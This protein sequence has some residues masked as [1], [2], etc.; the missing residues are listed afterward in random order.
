MASCFGPALARIRL[1]PADEYFGRSKMSILEMNN[2][3]NDC[4]FRAQRHVSP[5]AI[6]GDAQRTEDAMADWSRKYPSDP[7]LP[8]YWWRLGRLYAMMPS[9]AAHAEAN[10]AFIQ[11]HHYGHGWRAR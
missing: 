8:R 7:W 1:A 10:V 6:M 11:F 5:G 2:R 9:Q 4:T 3:L